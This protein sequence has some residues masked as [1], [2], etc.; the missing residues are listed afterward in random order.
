MTRGPAGQ[1]DAPLL[2]PLIFA[3]ILVGL[4]L[5]LSIWYAG[6][7]LGGNDEGALLTAAGRIL[8]GGVF[9]RDIDAYP[10]PARTTCWLPPWRSSAST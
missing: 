3:P 6:F 9:Y 2:R 5:C 7:R 1:G 4:G 10:F 8:R